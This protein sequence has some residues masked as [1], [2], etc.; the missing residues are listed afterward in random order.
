MGHA[1]HAGVLSRSGNLHARA[2]RAAA[3]H[4]AP[5]VR[6]LSLRWWPTPLP[7]D[8]V[9]LHGSTHCVGDTAAALYTCAGGCFPSGASSAD[10]PAAKGRNAD[11][12]RGGYFACRHQ[13]MKE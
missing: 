2:L 6:L 13:W 3:W 10:Y 8:D 1:S 7:G 11:A 5:A 9:R 4:E 12:Y